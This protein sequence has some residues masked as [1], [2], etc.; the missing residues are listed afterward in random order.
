VFSHFGELWL[1]E[2][3]GDGITS[4]MCA[5]TN[6][7]QAVDP[8]GSCRRG[9]VGIQNWVAQLGS[10]NWGAVALLKAIWWDLRLASLLTDLLYLVFDLLSKVIVESRPI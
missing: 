5:A 2:S 8:G 1:A 4:G 7:M 6:W 9:S 10:Q 3:H